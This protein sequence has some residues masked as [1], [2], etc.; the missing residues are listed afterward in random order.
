M[1]TTAIGADRGQ[2]D[3][4]GVALERY[5]DAAFMRDDKKFYLGTDGDFSIHYDSTSDVLMLASAFGA[6]LSDTLP[7][8]TGSL[9]LQSDVNNVSDYML[10]VRV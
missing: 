2:G 7:S 10:C 4:A 1:A 9:F 8:T 5:T 3:G 6:T